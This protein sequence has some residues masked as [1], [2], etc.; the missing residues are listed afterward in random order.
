MKRRLI[1]GNMMRVEI[2]H[3]EGPNNFHGY[4]PETAKLRLVFEYEAELGGAEKEAEAAFRLFNAPEECLDEEDA[5]IAR[6]YRK[7]HLRSLSVGDVV[8]IG[9]FALAVD[10]IGWKFV[11]LND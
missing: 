7:A 6:A 5:E 8:R 9:H 1:G 3:N 11:T 10:G 4:D 2:F